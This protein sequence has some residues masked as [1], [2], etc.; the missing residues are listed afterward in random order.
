MPVLC[1]GGCLLSESWKTLMLASV[2]A[3]SVAGSPRAPSS[4]PSSTRT[5]GPSATPLILKMSTGEKTVR[6]YITSANQEKHLVLFRYITGPVYPGGNFSSV[7][8]AQRDFDKQRFVR[9]CSCWAMRR[10]CSPFEEP[11]TP[12]IRL[13]AAVSDCWPAV[14]VTLLSVE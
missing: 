13:W 7:K 9:L 3:V 12:D 4:A 2:R 1:V 10:L 5:T 8:N 11:L 6:S 14:A